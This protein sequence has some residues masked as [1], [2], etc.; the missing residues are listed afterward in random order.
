MDVLISDLDEDTVKELE[1]QAKEN[2]RSF[3]AQLK[4]ILDARAEYRRRSRSFDST[5]L[6]HQMRYGYEWCG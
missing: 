6:I 1:E 5:D 2:N 3:E 4:A